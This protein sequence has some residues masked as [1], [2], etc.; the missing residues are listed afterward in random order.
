MCK[1]YLF[2][3]GIYSIYIGYSSKKKI[4]KLDFLWALALNTI[5][6]RFYLKNTS[7]EAQTRRIYQIARK[8]SNIFFFYSNIWLLFE[9]D[10]EQGICEQMLETS[11]LRYFWKNLAK[12]L[13]WMNFFLEFALLRVECK[14]LSISFLSF[15][16]M[17]YVFGVVRKLLWHN[18][19]II[20][21]VCYLWS[22]FTYLNVKINKIWTCGCKTGKNLF[23]N[24][25]E[26]LGEN[27][28]GECRLFLVYYEYHNNY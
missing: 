18:S 24:K 17:V 25:L 21:F 13:M 3:Y 19:G 23:G 27:F 7:Q 16:K 8:H 14:R 20:E 9:Y 28:F 5:R 26:K 15:F 4:L 22:F 10:F 6:A 1:L 12:Y 11:L 2:V